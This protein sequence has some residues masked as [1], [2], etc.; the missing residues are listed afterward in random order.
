MPRKSFRQKHSTNVQNDSISKIVCNEEDEIYFSSLFEQAGSDFDETA[1][2]LYMKYSQWQF[3]SMSFFAD[4]D[5]T[6]MEEIDGYCAYSPPSSSTSRMRTFSDEATGSVTG[7]ECSSPFFGDHS[8]D[9]GINTR[10]GICSNSSSSDRMET[11]HSWDS[12]NSFHYTDD[13]P[14]KYDRNSAAY[15]CSH[16]GEES[17]DYCNNVTFPD[18]GNDKVE[19]DL[20]N[21]NAYYEEDSTVNNVKMTESDDNFSNA[22]DSDL[23]SGDENSADEYESDDSEGQ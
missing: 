21:N 10:Y 13:F 22:S 19:W 12:R 20:E 3:D 5:D 16:L 9:L 2:L 7:M 8:N 15:L 17:Q 18:D 6:N 23:D 1:S 4:A 14:Q 11:L